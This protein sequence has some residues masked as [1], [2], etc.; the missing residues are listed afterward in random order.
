VHDDL[1]AECE[2]EIP[3]RRLKLPVV[4]DDWQSRKAVK[5][6]V[7]GIRA[8]APNCEGGNNI[9]RLPDRGGHGDF[10]RPL[11]AGQPQLRPHRDPARVAQVRVWAPEGGGIAGGHPSNILDNNTWAR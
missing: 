4:F 5:R 9:A 6:Y 3:S 10:L 2:M 11:L 1:P 7:D 8:D